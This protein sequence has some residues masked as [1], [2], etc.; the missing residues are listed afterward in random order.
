MLSSNASPFNQS[1]LDV[2]LVESIGEDA[3]AESGLQSLP[4]QRFFRH[5]TLAASGS[6]A[7]SA[8]PVIGRVSK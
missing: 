4:V 3:F 8:G 6:I 2:E 5:S 7:P 1:A